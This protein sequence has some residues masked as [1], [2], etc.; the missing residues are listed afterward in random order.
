MRNSEFENPVIL[1]N[2][3][4]ENYVG[5]NQESIYKGAHSMHNLDSLQTKISI[6]PKYCF[7]DKSHHLCT[8]LLAKRLEL[9]V[10]ENTIKTN[11]YG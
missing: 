2:S 7:I 8:P 6:T 9:T 11:N 10:D 1:F 3:F 4:T 5:Q